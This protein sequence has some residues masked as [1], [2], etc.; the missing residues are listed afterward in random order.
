MSVSH[1]RLWPHV[2]ITHIH[3]HLPPVW[4]EAHS[5]SQ[6][7]ALSASH[8][9][10]HRVNPSILLLQ[11]AGASGHQGRLI[12]E[13]RE[14]HHHHDARTEQKQLL[15]GAPVGRERGSRWRHG[16]GGAGSSQ[17]PL[18]PEP[19]KGPV[20]G[21]PLPPTGHSPRV[22]FFQEVREHVHQGDVEKASRGVGQDPGCRLLCSGRTPDWAPKALRML[23]ASRAWGPAV[24]QPNP[25]AGAPLLMPPAT[26]T[27]HARTYSLGGLGTDGKAGAQHAPQRC[28]ELQ[29]GCAP[30]VKASPEQDGKVAHLKGGP[31]VHPAPQ[32]GLI[33]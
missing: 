25:L 9:C 33:P 5:L 6:A 10:S 3:A 19:L 22:L 12:H 14:Q 32:Q 8:I 1:T 30:S 16:Q 28:R 26:T 18:P 4:W 7:L 13:D 21:S 17:E 15:Q 20:S 31:E 2:H 27:H 23:P 11:G 29:L 24:R